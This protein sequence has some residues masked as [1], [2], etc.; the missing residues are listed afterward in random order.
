MPKL[1]P[2]PLEEF[3]PK[4]LTLN[5]S[6]AGQALLDFWDEKYQE[7][8]DEIME[9]YWFKLPERCPAKFL[10]ELGYWLSAGILEV[11]SEMTKRL[12]IKSAVETHKIR[13][14]WINDAKNRIDSITG[15]SAVIYSSPGQDDWIMVGEDSEPV[16]Y[17][18][19]SLGVDGIDDDLGISLIGAGDELVV[20]GNV[21]INCHEGVYTAVLTSDEIENIVLQLRTDVLPCY[22]RIILG[23]ADSSNQFNE[24]PNGRI[25]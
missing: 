24:Y 1:L 13:G 5:P 16:N 9:M 19:A 21:Y 17:Y 7:L 11:D 15:Y 23:Y 20:G 4:L 8:S 6:D 12:K 2:I 25:E 22:M 10:N 3:I 18:T 14:S